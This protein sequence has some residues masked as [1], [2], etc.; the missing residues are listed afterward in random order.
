MWQTSRKGF[1]K[2]VICHLTNNDS[3]VSS[4]F[5]LFPMPFLFDILWWSVSLSFLSSHV[6]GSPCHSPSFHQMP[7]DFSAPSCSHSHL[8]GN[9]L[10]PLTWASSPIS[11]PAPHFLINRSPYIYHSLC[12]CSLS[13]C[14]CFILMFQCAI[15]PLD[16]VPAFCSYVSRAYLDPACPTCL[17]LQ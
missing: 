2:A 12:L 5:Y 11:P 9:H 14:L 6:S 1:N 10:I 4:Q 8:P 7:S 3:L 17:F 13:I 16:F 15:C